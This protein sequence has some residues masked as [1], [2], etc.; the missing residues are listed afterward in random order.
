MT[1]SAKRDSILEGELEETSTQALEALAVSLQEALVI[2]LSHEQRT[3]SKSSSE[4][5]NPLLGSWMMEMTTSSALDS[6]EALFSEAKEAEDWLERSERI[7]EILSAT[8]LVGLEAWEVPLEE[9]S[10]M[11]SSVHQWPRWKILE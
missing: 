2:S 4:E 8:H 10:R 11:T 9:V 6:G 5:G 7:E 1:L 3:F